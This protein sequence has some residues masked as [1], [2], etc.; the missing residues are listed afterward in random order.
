M[1]SGL[2]SIRWGRVVLGALVGFVIAFLINIIIPTVLGFQARGNPPQDKVVAALTSSTGQI[3]AALLALLG[4][5]VGGR[6]AARPA[7]TNRPL[8]GLVTGILLGIL[9]IAWRA[10]S[11]GTV[12]FWVLIFAVLAIA[13]GWLGGQLTARRTDEDFDESPQL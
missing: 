9:L 7:G 11:W 3:G 10:F 13:G 1:S 5:F 8:A 12:D 2:S 6:M 4:A